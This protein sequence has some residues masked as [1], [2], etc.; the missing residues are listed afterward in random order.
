M[1]D[2]P[3]VC[4]VVPAYNEAPCLDRLYDELTSVCDMLPFAFQFLFVDDGSTD[5]TAEV[6]DALRLKDE[7]VHCLALSRNFGHQGAL[8]AG[9]AYAA[10]DAVIMMDADLQHPPSLI[11]RLLE[12]WEDGFD[13]VNT[14][15]LGTETCSPFKRLFSAGFY[16]AF[17]ILTGFTIEPG[18]ADFRLMARKPLDALN[19][20]PERQRF[21]RGLVPWLGFRQTSVTFH[22]SARFSG[23]PKYTFAN[24]VRLALDG[25]TAFN[26]FPLRLV[27]LLGLFV[28]ASSFI[29]AVIMH[30]RAILGG[31][32][33]VSGW[34]SLAI[35]VHFLVGCQLT[36]MGVLGEYLGRALGQVMGRPHFIVQSSTT[37][38]AL[39]QSHRTCPEC[40]QRPKF[41]REAVA[42]E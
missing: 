23:S 42:S 20:L 27:A 1:T 9:L 10:G 25:M 19:R 2:K 38:A 40:A 11:P 35:S 8:S 6:I 41:A 21:I 37:S 22:A 34:T 39:P 14:L 28:I 15:R 18:C 26:L 7:R 12:R 36:A 13:V 29:T 17:R 4:I 24:S 31:G 3:S 33:S 16:C 32:P 30:G 5:D